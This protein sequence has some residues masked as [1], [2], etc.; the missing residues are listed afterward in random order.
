MAVAAG[1]APNL[2]ALNGFDRP[3]AIER[4]LAFVP[5]LSGLACPHWDCG[6]AGLWIGAGLET[7]AR[8]LAQSVLEGIALRTAE[9]IEAM[10][11]A[12]LIGGRITSAC[13]VCF[14]ATGLARTVV[15]RD[16]DDLT[17]FSCAALAAVGLGRSLHSPGEG[18]RMIEP[19]SG[20]SL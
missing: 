1:L 6:T 10:S 16:F 20:A 18:E 11:A 12:A 2:D 9:V 17:A 7:D 3:Q 19:E 8:D 15:L 4:G 13:F 5:A 14:L